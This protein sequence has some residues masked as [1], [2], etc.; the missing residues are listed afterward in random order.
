MSLREGTDD[1]LCEPTV[2]LPAPLNIMALARRI[3]KFSGTRA[4]KQRVAENWAW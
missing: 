3:E 1:L 2:L 4:G